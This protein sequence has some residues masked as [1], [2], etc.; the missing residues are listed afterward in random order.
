MPEPTKTASAPSCI[1]SAASAGVAIPPA[2][3]L[4]TGSL[5][6]HATRL[7][8]LGLDEVADPRVGHLVNR[9]GLLDLLDL[10]HRGQPRDAAILA[11]I[12]GHAL[13]RHHRGR[14]C[15]F[16]DLR[17]LGRRHVHDPPALEHLGEAD[18]LAVR[19]PDL[20]QLRHV[21]A[22]FVVAV[23]A[24]SRPPAPD[25]WV[26]HPLHHGYGGGLGPAPWPGP[27]PRRPDRLRP[28]PDPPPQPPP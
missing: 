9:D 27:A 6:V 28:P 21:N 25:G 7:E 16:G 18:V 24:P 10:R 15:V 8:D 20:V 2:E 26:V 3:K 14:P 12:G 5:P 4:G 22:S 19:N 1:M 17:L 11:D 13:E 23:G